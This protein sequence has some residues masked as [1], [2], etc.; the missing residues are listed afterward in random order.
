[1]WRV[2]FIIFSYKQRRFLSGGIWMKY[3]PIV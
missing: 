3:D 2:M 1:L